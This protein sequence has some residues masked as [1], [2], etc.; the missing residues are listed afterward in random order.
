MSRVGVDQDHQIICKPCILDAGVLA[1]AR[2]F[3][4]SLQHSVDLVEVEIAEQWRDHSPY[5]KGNFEFKR[6]VTG[7]RGRS[8]LDLRLKR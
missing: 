7:W 4:R 6:V 1:E 3:F 5:T 8:V 2:G